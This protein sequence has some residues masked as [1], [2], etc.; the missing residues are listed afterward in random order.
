MSAA[1]T[2]SFGGVDFCL[3]PIK[4]EH[5]PADLA[6]PVVSVSN[7]NEDEIVISLN[8]FT[9]TLRVNSSL[10]SRK[11][12]I[13][14]DT[15]SST[16]TQDLLQ[17]YAKIL[18]S[19]QII[20]EDAIA[21]ESEDLPGSKPVQFVRDKKMARNLDFADD[22]ENPPTQRSAT[23]LEDTPSPNHPKTKSLTKPKG[24]QRLNFTAKPNSKAKKKLETFAL[25][26]K[27]RETR[28]TKRCASDE[29]TQM[30]KKF[31]ND[32]K[33]DIIIE[34]KSSFVAEQLDEDK[35]LPLNTLGQSMPSQSTDISQSLHQPNEILPC[36]L[37]AEANADEAFN[38]N[39]SFSMEEFSQDCIGEGSVASIRTADIKSD[40]RK[41]NDGAAEDTNSLQNSKKSNT[42]A[43]PAARWGHTMEMI[44]HKRLIV[45]GGQTIDPA[46]FDA[47][48]LGDIMVYDI[49]DHTWTEPVNCKGVP[50][51]WHS[52]NFLPDRQLLLCFGGD[53][54]DD[55]TGKTT[56][57]DQVMVLDTE[58]MLWYPPSVTGT[59][60]KS[61]S[62]HSASLLHDSSQLIVFGGV[63][64]G[65]WINSVSI[66]ETNRWHWSSPKIMGDAPR[67][68][69]YHSATAVGD[70]I[71]FI[72]GNNGKECF[73]SVHVLESKGG[74]SWAWSHP[75]VGGKAPSP[76]TGHVATLL[77]D[78]KTILIYGGWDPNT[79]DD[80]G[81]DTIFGDSFLLD[82]TTW[83][84]QKGPRPRFVGDSKKCENFGA[85]RVGHSA[86]K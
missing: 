63:S 33:S 42:F 75:K 49:L 7:I 62:G 27:T 40:R 36:A 48:N 69:S 2:L 23:I 65:K 79:E 47:K 14:C 67:P 80:K 31:R 84:W 77:D 16:A 22:N 86:G 18:S 46:T 24:Q 55:K 71:I 30:K 21:Q 13:F 57:T 26:E 73:N 28:A 8:K 1:I 12:N 25:K 3:T 39:F 59:T 64:N 74:D 17:K 72:G 6:E 82:T 60:P 68:R 43:V 78:N 61:R 29:V 38:S 5:K 66:L 44:D 85:H 37:H 53:M 83:T 10:S 45:Y 4:H 35:Q 20:D 54:I 50:R 32:E 51:T 70:C 41:G 81:D 56:A 15:A 34:S 58:I 52:S 11:E 9:G 76:R 19:A